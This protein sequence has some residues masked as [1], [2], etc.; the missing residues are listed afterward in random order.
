MSFW[1]N[2]GPHIGARV[3]RFPRKSEGKHLLKRQ[4]QITEN[5]RTGKCEQLFTNHPVTP[6]LYGYQD[7]KDE[8]SWFHPTDRGGGVYVG[9]LNLLFSSQ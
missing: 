6:V 2:Q 3:R 8:T 5:L 1:G 4:Q 7:E 9:T